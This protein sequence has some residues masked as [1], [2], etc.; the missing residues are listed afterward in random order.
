MFTISVETH[1][2]ASHQ[3]ALKDEA[4]E[5]L[6]Q[7][8][9]SVTAEVSSERLDEMG[10]VIDFH[11]L[12]ALLQDIIDGLGNAYIG[13]D[14]YFE[15]NN[16]SAETLALYMYEQL[17]PKLPVGVHLESILIGE[18]PGCSVKYSK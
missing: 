2:W 12:K 18:E 17:E 8:N 16:C 6:H 11:R 9:W 4:R 14:D 1:F 7:H 3:L 10:L 13:R 5:P 15:Q